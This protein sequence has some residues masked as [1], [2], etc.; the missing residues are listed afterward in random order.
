MRLW[1][2]ERPLTPRTVLGERIVATRGLSLRFPT[3]QIHAETDWCCLDD[4]RHLV[5]VHRVGQLQSMEFEVD[6]GPSGRALLSRGDIWVIPAGHRCSSLVRG[7]TMSYCEISIPDRMLGTSP[8]IPRINHRDPLVWHLL[9]NIYSVA[10]R[11]GTVA[12]LLKDSA[13]ETL[14]LL[15]CDSYSATVQR[16]RGGAP[17]TLDSATSSMLVEYLEDGLDSEITLESLARLA[18]MPVS[19]FI[20]A[21]R[22]AFHATP[23]QFLL[24]L[25]INRAKTLLLTTSRTVSDISAAA[26]FA[27]P[28]HF[29]AVFR[30][31]VG[32]SPRDY[33]ANR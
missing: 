23:Y 4:T 10:D 20:K 14:R 22:S 25:R 21:F 8:M 5:Y 16:P 6:W 33:R 7:D 29:A 2:G 27:T 1:A 28:S 13:T 26:G 17:H 24:D 3:E 31:R 32:V 18:Q 15:L 12:R 9:E 30:R 19:S 11:D